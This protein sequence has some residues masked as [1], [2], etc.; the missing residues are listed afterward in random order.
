[1]IGGGRAV[2]RKR[3]PKELRA[4][5]NQCNPYLPIGLIVVPSTQM[6]SV[7]ATE[8]LSKDENG[9]YRWH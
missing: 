3:Y 6:H 9:T 2:V 8:N 5:K 4:L 7:G 1:M